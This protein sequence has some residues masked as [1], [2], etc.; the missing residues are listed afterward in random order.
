MLPGTHS[1]TTAGFI[2]LAYGV[3][4]GVAPAMQ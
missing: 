4:Q 3:G 2:L 1:L